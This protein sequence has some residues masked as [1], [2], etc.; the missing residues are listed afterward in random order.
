MLIVII[1][2]SGAAPSDK[3]WPGQLAGDDVTDAAARRCPLGGLPAPCITLPSPDRPP[4]CA[5]G[6]DVVVY[7]VEDGDV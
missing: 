5:V 2:F 1:L 4:F 7:F 3:V 6:P